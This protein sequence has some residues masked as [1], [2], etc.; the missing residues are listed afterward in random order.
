MAAYVMLGKYSQAALKGVT[1][2][3]T[4]RV[5]N[6]I[7]KCKGQVQDIYALLGGYD[8]LILAEFPG[9][10]EAMKASMAITKTTGIAFTSLP[11]VT[12]KEFDKLAAK[13]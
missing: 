10:Q 11:A 12:V 5:V 3:R 8:L 9:T 13:A 6:M 4:K 1:P 2:Q 7:K